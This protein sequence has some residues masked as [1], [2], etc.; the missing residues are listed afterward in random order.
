MNKKI[1]VAFLTCVFLL[2]AISMGEA[3]ESGRKWGVGT[4]LSLNAPMGR[5]GDQFSPSSKFGMSWQYMLNK[6]LYL[7]MEY[8]RSEFNHGKLEEQTFTWSVDGK[9]YLSPEASTQ[10][11][12]DGGAVNL[13]IFHQGAPS[14]KGGAFAYYFQVGGGYYHYKVER[15]NFIFPGQRQEPLDPT[16]VLQPQID[17]KTALTLNAGFGI[18][19]FP[20]DRIALDL[21]ARYN[22]LMGEVRPM[23]DWGIEN[24]TFP[25]MLL[26]IG[27][28]VKFYFWKE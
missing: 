2:T 7:E 23:W 12:F 16:L 5:L 6:K 22:V 19:A 8:H 13:L 11:N 26:D 14:L 17:S 21:R 28:G 1:W 3:Q 27:A 20:I 24:K 10:M 4:F 9:D 15:R 25:M 18:Q